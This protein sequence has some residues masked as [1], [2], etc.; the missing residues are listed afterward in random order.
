M[1]GLWLEFCLTF[2]PNIRNLI[3][4]ANRM[5]EFKA[6][7]WRLVK[8]CSGKM[9][10]WNFLSLLQR[11]SFSRLLLNLFYVGMMK[12]SLRNYSHLFLRH[13]PV[14]SPVSELWRQLFLSPL[15]GLQCLIRTDVNDFYIIHLQQ[16]FKASFLC[17]YGTLGLDLSG[18]I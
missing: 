7:K 9:T 17:Q 4:S 14:H 8:C 12:P 15:L 5:L 3:R 10:F 6:R 11:E 13:S 16:L 18:N 1:S 2:L